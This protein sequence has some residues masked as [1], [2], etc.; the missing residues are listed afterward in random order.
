MKTNNKSFPRVRIAMAVAPIIAM[1]PGLLWAAN[2]SRFLAPEA[3]Q[4]TFE[5]EMNQDV[6]K[7]TGPGGMAS[8]SKRQFFQALESVGTKV[9][10][11]GGNTDSYHQ[12][13]E[14][15]VKGKVRLHS[16]YDGGSDGIQIAGWQNGGADVHAKTTF[17]R[18]R[19]KQDGDTRQNSNLRR[20]YQ[21]GRR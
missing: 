18:D 14:Q 17:C 20:F 16:V 9:E 10:S 7:A 4:C 8:D 6:E 21:A 11:P 1:L 5:A 13:I 19:A 3:W 15:T 12:K 2:A